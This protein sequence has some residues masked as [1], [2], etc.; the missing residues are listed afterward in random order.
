MP[1]RDTR[2]RHSPGA[3]RLSQVVS[4]LAH[5]AE[6]DALVERAAVEVA[7]LFSADIAVLMLGPD[8]A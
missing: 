6:F 7:E 8:D 1:P 4:V 2:H 3:T 5:D